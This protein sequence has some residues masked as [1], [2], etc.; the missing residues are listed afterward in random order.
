MG[1]VF[2]LPG[3]QVSP[4]P[5]GFEE[6]IRTRSLRSTGSIFAQRSPAPDSQ[7]AKGEVGRLAGGWHV[8]AGTRQASWLGGLEADAQA[9][10]RSSP[11]SWSAGDLVDG[12]GSRLLDVDLLRLTPLGLVESQFFSA[13]S[14]TPGVG[15]PWEMGVSVPTMV[16][17]AAR[18]RL[19]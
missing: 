9:Q 1:E 14:C 15:R 11:G 19:G 7:N 13:G 4:L 5:D 12:H 2:D 18:G 8:R 6:I 10:T 16:S 17:K 3:P